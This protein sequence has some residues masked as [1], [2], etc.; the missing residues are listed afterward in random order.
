MIERNGKNKLDQKLETPASQ[1]NGI[2]RTLLLLLYK[3]VSNFQY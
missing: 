3:P 1:D 2:K